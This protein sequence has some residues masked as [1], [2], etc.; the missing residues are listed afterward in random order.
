[1]SNSSWYTELEGEFVDNY[2]LLKFVGQGKVGVVYQ[3]EDRAVSGHTLALKITKG[4]PRDGWENELKKVA[5]LSSIPGVVQFHGL[6]STHLDHAGKTNQLQYT[7]WDYIAPGRSLK[8]YLESVPSCTTSFLIAVLDLILRVLNACEKREVPRHGDLHAGNILI[9]DPDE[10]DLDDSLRPRVRIYVS[11]FGYGTTQG[12]K[13][14]KDD[15]SG[16]A[17]IAHSILQKL[18]WS[19]ATGRDRNCAMRIRDTMGKLLGEHSTS[20][21]RRPFEIL[22]T[23]HEIRTESDRPFS[24]TSAHIE[25]AELPVLPTTRSGGITLGQFQVSEMLGDSWNIWRQLF[26]ATVPARSRILEAD[27]STVVTGPRGCGKTMLFRRLSERLVLE[28]GQLTQQ[29]N[30]PDFV[31]FYVNANDFADP[32]DAFPERPS[33]KITS[34][35]ICYANLCFLSEFLAVLSTR[36]YKNEDPPSAEILTCVAHLLIDETD[37]ARLVVWESLLER[38]RT[39]LEG[40]KAGFPLADSAHFPGYGEMAQHT[41]LRSFVKRM[42]A[43]CPW[44]GTRM[45]YLFIDDYTMPRVSASMQRV[46]NRLF[47]QRSS[48][49]VCKIATEAA[50]TFLPEDSTS[51]VLQDGDDYQLIDIAEETLAMDEPERRAFLDEIFKRRLASD[52]RIP[53][54]MTSLEALLGTL[55]MSKTEFARRLRERKPDPDQSTPAL[56]HRRGAT[57]P[58]ALYHGADIFESLWSGDT[59]IMIQLAQD[60]LD[61]ALLNGP[62]S[63]GCPI[64]ADT[65]DRVFRNR[66][67][68]WLEAQTRNQPSSQIASETALRIL[69]KSNPTYQFTGGSYGAHLK[70]IVE[71]FVAVARGLLLGPTYKILEE[72]RKREVP[73][74]AFRIEIVD[75]FRPNGLPAEIYKDLVRYGLF[76]RDARGKSVRG[77]MVPRLYLR[78]FLLPYCTLAISKRDSVQLKFRQFEDLL[79]FPDQ[80]KRTME[81][82]LAARQDSELLQTELFPSAPGNDDDESGG[83]GEPN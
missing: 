47:F 66:G 5:R 14:P 82:D 16:L 68:M 59:R 23:L 37:S 42:R 13:H 49:W 24:A 56:E 8:S 80:F 46:L 18:D 31:G 44:L 36:A 33:L 63:L 70:A 71:A 53:E 65:Q 32:F 25:V 29:A 9:A 77:A 15:Y 52:P 19:S 40:V 28:C 83:T 60:L 57:K 69:R 35:L 30:G 67:G 55:G 3:A 7:L 78:R 54:G 50:T 12:E 76:M 72:G 21:R 75:D 1:M 74:M 51:K 20:E 27:I 73:R 41:W 81:R 17:E 45:I 62:P 6:H 2:R 10:A 39:A 61:E 64:A 34:R 22:Q 11:D 26:V 4:H 58:R 79:L 43:G 38:L 48:D